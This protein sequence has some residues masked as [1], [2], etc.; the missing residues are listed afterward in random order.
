MWMYAM[1]LNLKKG[2]EESMTYGTFEITTLILISKSNMRRLKGIF[3]M[4]FGIK[5]LTMNVG[6]N[7]RN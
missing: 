1:S 5:A 2:M 3:G 4:N 6:I 7:R